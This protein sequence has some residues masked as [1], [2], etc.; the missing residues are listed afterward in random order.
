MVTISWKFKF[1]SQDRRKTKNIVKCF[2]EIDKIIELQ[3]MISILWFSGPQFWT[4][5]KIV[6]PWKS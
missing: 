5:D 3:T 2:S 4:T 1:N 6:R